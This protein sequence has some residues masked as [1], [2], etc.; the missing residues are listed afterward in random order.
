MS[1]S[2]ESASGPTTATR[3]GAA[4]APSAPGRTSGS[5]PSFA[6][7][8]SDSCARRRAVARWRGVSRS[9]AVGGSSA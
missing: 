3:R 5:T 1:A 8:T 7:S 9:T 6:S 2:A 4:D